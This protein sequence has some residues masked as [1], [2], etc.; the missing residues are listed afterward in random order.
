MS[1][2]FLM[3]KMY[4]LERNV[5]YLSSCSILRHKRDTNVELKLSK[6]FY[7]FLDNLVVDKIPLVITSLLICIMLNSAVIACVISRRSLR[8]ICWVLLYNNEWLWFNIIL[9][10]IIYNIIQHC[11]QSTSSSYSLQGVAFVVLFP[12]SRCM[13]HKCLYEYSAKYNKVVHNAD[14][15]TTGLST[16]KTNT[17]QCLSVITL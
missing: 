6:D 4:I 15:D 8:M 5:L 12:P 2:L 3:L 1:Q 9:G 11:Y 7:H 14:R 17:D 10:C 16:T 13:S